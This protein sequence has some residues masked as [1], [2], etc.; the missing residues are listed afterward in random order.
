MSSQFVIPGFG[1]KISLFADVSNVALVNNRLRLGG[2]RYP[3]TKFVFSKI[4]SNRGDFFFVI[5]DQ[6]L[7]IYETQIRPK[8]DNIRKISTWNGFRYHE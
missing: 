5:V 8:F 3:I 6:N 7:W 1:Y 4:F 2:W